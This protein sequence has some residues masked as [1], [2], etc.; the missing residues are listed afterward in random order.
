MENLYVMENLVFR[1]G[2]RTGLIVTLIKQDLQEYGLYVQTKLTLDTI[3]ILQSSATKLAVLCLA[4]YHVCC[5]R[6]SL[7]GA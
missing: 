2:H 6:T 4:S 7:I 5:N 3:N 1:T